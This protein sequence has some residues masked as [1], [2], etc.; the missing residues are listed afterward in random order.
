MCVALTDQ[1][2]VKTVNT[3]SESS[4]GDQFKKLGE[5]G[6]QMAGTIDKYHHLLAEATDQRDFYREQLILANQS[7]A[8]TYG[9]LKEANKKIELLEKKPETHE[10]STQT[11][12]SSSSQYVIP[13]IA[14]VAGAA[15]TLAAK[16]LFFK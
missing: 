14:F 11:E 5:I 9:Q 2:G 6:D 15:L 16:S 3:P 12:A 10:A 4:T 7:Q 13:A 8:A 1:A